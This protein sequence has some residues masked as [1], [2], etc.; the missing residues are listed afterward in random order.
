MGE[1]EILQQ[2]RPYSF[3][4]QSKHSAEVYKSSYIEMIATAQINTGIKKLKK[5]YVREKQLLPKNS[6]AHF[7]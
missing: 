3:T 7:L 4:A 2:H 1:D 5:T 6:S